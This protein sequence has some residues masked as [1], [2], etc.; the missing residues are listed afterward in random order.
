M[1]LLL[2]SVGG[3]S[4]CWVETAF[5]RALGPTGM[6]CRFTVRADGQPA[7]RAEGSYVLDLVVTRRLTTS[8]VSGQEWWPRKTGY[9]RGLRLS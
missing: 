6:R 4:G 3:G 1:G 7:Q 5:L 2:E 9:M 8:G